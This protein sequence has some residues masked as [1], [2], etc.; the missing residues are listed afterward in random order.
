MLS[1]ILYFSSSFLSDSNCLDV[2]VNRTLKVIT[3][4]INEVEKYM[5]D[6]GEYTTTIYVGSPP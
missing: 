5:L 1:K 4:E 3:K 2:L 6:H